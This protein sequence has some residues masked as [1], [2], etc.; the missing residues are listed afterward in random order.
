MVSTGCTGMNGMNITG[1]MITGRP[2]RI[3]SLIWK[4]PDGVASLATAVIFAARGDED[5]DDQASVEPVPPR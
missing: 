3:G 5:G 2:N 4:M 1:F